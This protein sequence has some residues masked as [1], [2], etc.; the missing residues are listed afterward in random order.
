MKLKELY[1]QNAAESIKLGADEPMIAILA[2]HLPGIGSIPGIPGN[3]TGILVVVKSFEEDF[4]I[5][6]EGIS[7]PYTFPVV[8]LSKEQITEAKAKRANIILPK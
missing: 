2:V 5:T 8:P 1:E 7:I 3:G 6:A 4:F